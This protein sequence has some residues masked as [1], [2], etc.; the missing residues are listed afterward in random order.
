MTY[1]FAAAAIVLLLAII[2]EHVR[3]S[4]AVI[5]PPVPP[6]KLERYPSITVIRPI[7]GLDAG[8]K[9][10][11]IALLE[12]VYPGEVQTL[13]VFDHVGDP[14]LPLVSELVR[15]LP[16]GKN[17]QVLI[18]GPPPPQRTGK[19]NAMIC[20]LA[21]ARG[22]LIAFNDS[23]TRPTPYLLRLLADALMSRPGIGCTFTPVVTHRPPVTVGEAGY[24]LLVNSW[25]GPSVT[26]AAGPRGELPFIMGELMLLTR[27]AIQKIGGLECCEGQLVDDMHLG[28][29]IAKVGL[30][31]VMVR[32]PLPIVTDRLSLKE[33]FKLFRRWI[34]CSTSGLPAS[35]I[36]AN[37]LRG[38]EAGGAIALTVA[39]LFTMPLWA[40]LPAVA[41]LVAFTWSQLE[42]HEKFSGQR[43]KK[44]HAWVPAALP[45]AGGVVMASTKIDPKVDWRGRSYSLDEAAR[46]AR[47]QEHAAG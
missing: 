46:L 1:L 3:L 12:Q 45:L 42:L 22:E 20:G 41:A 11:T 24:A 8:C 32:W 18:A 7:R 33:F 26:A 29:C 39:G 23:D 16:S 25:Y 44:R 6:R 9:E 19:L 40:T 37:W 38:I 35:F 31:N 10:N 28:R 30:K 4:R 15:T 36:R 21:H 2:I 17:A 13:F 27:E 14:A 34:A 43:L 47:E 5:R